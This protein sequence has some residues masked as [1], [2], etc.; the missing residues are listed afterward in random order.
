MAITPGQARSIRKTHLAGKLPLNRP[1]TAAAGNDAFLSNPAS[2]NVYLYLTDYVARLVECWSGRPI[3]KLSI[4]DWGC[5]KGHV[6][7][8]LKEMG[9]DVAACDV[10]AGAGGAILQRAGVSLVTLEHEHIL[11]FDSGRFDAV[12]GF[13]VLEHV[14]SEIDS[15]REIH[16]VLKD[17][18]LLF[19]F[20]V[21][22]FLS[23]TQRLMRLR[24]NLY[25]HRLY[26]KRNM[27]ELIRRADFE[28]LDIWHRQ[29]LP[30]IRFRYPRYRLFETI[31][32]F[33]TNYSLL[34]YLATNI[35]LA[36][37]KR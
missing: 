26:S 13:G 22:Y 17:G 18:G 3:S 1:L 21:P 35:E 4:L 25:H 34:K 14:A 7:L 5:G 31:D 33:L 23:W 37:C 29:L 15:L 11:P 12:V 24:G 28:I 27:R 36:A 20:F 32:Q 30:K 9:A 16:R 10:E 19:C 6:T 2:Q 8:L